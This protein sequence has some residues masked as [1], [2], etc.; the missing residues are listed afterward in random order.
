MLDRTAK[1]LRL[2]ISFLQRVEGQEVDTVQMEGM[3][4]LVVV[5]AQLHLPQ[6][7]QS[8]QIYQQLHGGIM[9]A[10]ELLQTLIHVT[11]VANFVTVVQEEAEHRVKDQ[12]VQI[13]LR[14]VLLELVVQD[15][16]MISQVQL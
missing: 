3:A 14:D 2:V 16:Q 13:Q 1:L 11:V 10:Q 8:P 5:G 4:G 12:A 9:A 7:L 6:V 15:I